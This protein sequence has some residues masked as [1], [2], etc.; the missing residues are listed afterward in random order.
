MDTHFLKKHKMLIMIGAMS[1]AVVLVSLPKKQSETSSQDTWDTYIPAGHVLI[2]ID[3]EN[4]ESLNEM[5]DRFGIVDLYQNKKG[6]GVVMLAS[7]VK[8]LRSPLNQQQMGVLV[9]DQFAAKIVQAEGPFKV[10]VKNPKGLKDPELA[11]NRRKII[12]GRPNGEK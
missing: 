4:F 5:I 12:L 10:I 3:V 7:Q 1:L 8:L 11:K 2:P 9:P 6:L